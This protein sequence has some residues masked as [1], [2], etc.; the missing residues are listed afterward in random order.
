MFLIISTHSGNCQ[1]RITVSEDGT[2]IDEICQHSLK[3]SQSRFQ[4]HLA[5]RE[6]IITYYTARGQYQSRPDRGFWLSF[7]QIR[8]TS[9]RQTGMGRQDPPPTQKPTTD[10]QKTIPPPPTHP[11]HSGSSSGNLFLFFIITCLLLTR[12][13]PQPQFQP[14]YPIQL[15]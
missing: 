8:G 12:L 6:I 1:D 5:G 7:R 15:F 13:N 14:P 3:G 4:Y 2:F 10:S 9:K 11:R